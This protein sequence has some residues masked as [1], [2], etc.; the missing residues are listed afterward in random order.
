MTKTAGT[1]LTTELRRR[2]GVGT[3]TRRQRRTDWG[4]EDLHQTMV[5]ALL[6][7]AQYDGYFSEPAQTLFANAAPVARSYQKHVEGYRISGTKIAAIHAMSPWQFA[8][9]LGQMVDAGI[10]NVGQGERFL[11]SWQVAA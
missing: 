5:E 8:A 2:Y 7:A 3:R 9:F 4:R 1:T 11:N 10:E 6:N